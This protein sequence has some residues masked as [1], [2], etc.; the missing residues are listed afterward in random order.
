MTLFKM[1][2]ENDEVVV[3]AS[4]VPIGMKLAAETTGDSTWDN[5]RTR[6]E[7][8]VEVVREQGNAEVILWRSN[9]EPDKDRST[10][11]KR[12]RKAVSGD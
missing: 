8:T 9:N 11:T 5:K 12:S 4:N 7:I 1:K 2:K 6:S 10:T 3:R